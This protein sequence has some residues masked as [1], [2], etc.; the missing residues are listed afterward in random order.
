[1]GKRKK[2]SLQHKG[3]DTGAVEKIRQRPS[4]PFSVLTNYTYDA[5]AKNM[6]P[7]RD[8]SSHAWPCWT[9]FLEAPPMPLLKGNAILGMFALENLNYST[10]TYLKRDF[11]AGR[12]GKR[13]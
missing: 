11:P 9:D 5:R 3:F 8:E 2:R 1:M 7:L 13:V 12:E 6:S 10:L 4:R